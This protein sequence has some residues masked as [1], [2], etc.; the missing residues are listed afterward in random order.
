LEEFLI[1]S[2]AGSGG[3]LFYDRS[4]HDPVE[5]VDSYWVRVT[6]HNLSA[7]G[8]VY[9]GYARTNPAL[10]FADMARQW[11]GWTGVLLWESL[12]G[13][14]AMRC[15]RDRVGHIFIR[16]ELRSRQMPGDWRVDATIM[17]EAGQLEDISRRAALF[18]GRAG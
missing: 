11:S 13:E 7:S 8:Q 16:V 12:E 15:S 6:D 17:A 9:A 4:P 5:P 1:P 14:L 10:L 18:F 2:A 3:L